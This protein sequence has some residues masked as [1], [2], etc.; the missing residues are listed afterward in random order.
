ME[1][2]ATTQWQSL[3]ER[4]GIL[5]YVML[6]LRVGK[7]NQGKRFVVRLQGHTC[8]WTRFTPIGE[9]SQGKTGNYLMH[10]IKVP[11]CMSENVR[12]QGGLIKYRGT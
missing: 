8:I 12:G 10:G 3:K 2:E 1:E 4:K 6:K 5:E 9:L 11:L 7:W